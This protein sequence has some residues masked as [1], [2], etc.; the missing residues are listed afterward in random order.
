MMRVKV[1]RSRSALLEWAARAGI[2]LAVSLYGFLGFMAGSAE[3]VAT[4]VLYG[5]SFAAQ[6]GLLWYFIWKAK[7]PPPGFP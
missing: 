1:P 6:M 4:S 3:G 2:A 5:F 7:G